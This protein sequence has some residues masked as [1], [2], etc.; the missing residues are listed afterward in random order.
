MSQSD[1]NN[2]KESVSMQGSASHKPNYTQRYAALCPHYAQISQ[3]FF[4]GFF[5]L[6]EI[7]N[8][9]EMCFVGG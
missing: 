5:M 8:Y 1:I 6:A 7:V 9:L 3:Q 4:L 2:M